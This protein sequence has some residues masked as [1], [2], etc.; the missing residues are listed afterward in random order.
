MVFSHNKTVERCEIGYLK[1]SYYAKELNSSY[2]GTRVVYMHELDKESFFQEELYAFAHKMDKYMI[3]KKDGTPCGQHPD[4]PDIYP[5]LDMNF[6]E[7]PPA[8]LSGLTMGV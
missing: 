5:G 4:I 6:S 8:A 2:P 1:K 3:L 7:S